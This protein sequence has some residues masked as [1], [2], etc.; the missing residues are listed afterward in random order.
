MT[1]ADFEPI[2]EYRP[3]AGTTS[4]AEPVEY[5]PEGGPTVEADPV[6]VAEQRIDVELDDAER[7]EDEL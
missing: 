3:D 4:E 5:E 7:S 1:S 2:D 6:D